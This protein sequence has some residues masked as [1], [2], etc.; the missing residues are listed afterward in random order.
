MEAA[1]FRAGMD[2]L[3]VTICLKK[4]HQLY[5]I[6]YYLINNLMLPNSVVG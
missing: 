2:T 3:E 5:N 4:L 1:N 6:G